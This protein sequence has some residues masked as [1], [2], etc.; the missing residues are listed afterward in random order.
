MTEL[1]EIDGVGP[2]RA[3][4]LR[5]MGY[6]DAEAV[7]EA[8]AEDLTELA[9]VGEDK[10]LEM[11][12][13]AQNI[14]SDE[15]EPE[16]ETITFDEDDLEDESEEEPER[17]EDAEPE[18]EEEDEEREFDVSLDLDARQQEILTAA[19]LNQYTSLRSRNVARSNAC[20]A[21]LTKFRGGYDATLTEDEL[22]AVH[23]AVRQRRMDYQGNNHISLMQS[24]RAIEEQVTA[25]REEYLF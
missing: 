3:D 14:S 23:A 12:V 16:D 15:D 22:N 25:I 13:A 2:A 5:E 10:A 24:A 18:V 6:E 7:A 19:L 4:D 17:E 20:D 8:E 21:A 9:R 11:I 1:T